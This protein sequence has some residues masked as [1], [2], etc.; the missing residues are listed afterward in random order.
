[1][2]HKE[3]DPITLEVIRHGMVDYVDFT[4]PSR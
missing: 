2:T 4:S 3:L 1:M